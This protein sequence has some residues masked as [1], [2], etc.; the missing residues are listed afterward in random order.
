MNKN[1]LMLLASVGAA[2]LMAS[3]ASEE[4]SLGLDGKGT[5]NLSLTSGTEFTISARALTESNYKNVN[6][7][8]V[9]VVNAINGTVVDEFKGSEISS[10]FPKTLNIGSYRINAF[11]GTEAPA[12]RNNFL[13][14]GST[15]FNIKGEDNLDVAVKCAPTCGRL[16]VEFSPEMATYFTNYEVVYGGTKALGSSTITWAKSDVEP[17]YVLLDEAGETV[18]YTINLTTK[19]DFLQTINGGEGKVDAQVTGTIQLQRNKA[20]KLTVSPT[21]TPTTDGGM[22]LTITIDEGTNDK[23]ITIEVPVTWI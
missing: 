18:N 20:H 1:F 5:V 3:C 16:S 22:K 15:T 13:V 21:Y 17:W 2:S 12:S 7:Y 4:S 19:E 6:N 9:Q 11:Y 10:K 14:T 8:T 23:E